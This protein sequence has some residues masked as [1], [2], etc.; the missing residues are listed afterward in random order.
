M[1]W[2]TVI[3]SIG[4]G[5]CVTLALIELFVWLK[6]RSERASLAL[7]VLAISVAAFA[8]LELAL[9][10][11]QT[12]EQLGEIVRW[13]HV[14]AW[15]M[16]TSLVTFT[17]LYLR[18]GR[19]WLAWMVVGVRTLS[20]IL[21]FVFS[22][23]INFREITA[24]R[25]I[26]FLGETVSSPAG[27]PNPWMLVAQLSL[28]LLVIFVIDAA[29]AVWR[30]G[31]RREALVVGGSIVFFVVISSAQAVA[32]TWGI[33]SMPMTASLFYQCLV[34]AMA[35][36]IGLRSAPC[37][38]ARASF[39]N[40]RGPGLLGGE[41]HMRLAGQLRPAVAAIACELEES[42]SRADAARLGVWELDTATN[43]FWVSDKCPSS[44]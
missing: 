2:V 29:I 24:V 26:S 16:I 3:W 33:I 5:A 1:S 30:R 43:G 39:A 4:A 35:V 36:R 27:V 38:G 25:Q 7:S 15:V 6:D 9:M 41:K 20:L 17:R 8:G 11:A 42:F 37:S 18:A 31:D 13:L 32:I 40:D 22:P 44:V 12:P 19:L 28:V 34:G 21:N 10:R 23:N 14:P